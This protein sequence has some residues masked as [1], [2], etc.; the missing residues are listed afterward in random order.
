MTGTLIAAVLGVLLLVLVVTAALGASRLR[1]LSGRIGAFE[2]G[3][4]PAGSAW[5]AGIAHYGAG[6][7][8]WWRSW[9]LAPRPALTWWRA[10]LELLGRAPLDPADP[11][12]LVV[13]CRYHGDD[14]EL[15]MSADAL[16]GLTAW[17]EAAPPT[18]A[19]RVI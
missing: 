4:R 8:E 5:T 10:D 19:R 15:S 1:V 12:T 2:C 7:I 11:G 6:R 18:D 3:T 14:L 17:L 13:L 9:S 16:A